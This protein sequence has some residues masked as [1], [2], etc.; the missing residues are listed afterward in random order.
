MIKSRNMPFDNHENFRSSW[1][2]AVGAT[3]HLGPHWTVSARHRLGSDA[4]DQRLPPV[5]PLPDTDRYLLGFGTRVDLTDLGRYSDGAYGHSFA[6]LRPNMDVSANN[7]DPIT[8]AVAL[9]GR[10]DIAVDIVAFSV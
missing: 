10:Y 4:C 8:H 2:L 5:S 1:M 9:K 3:Y 6:F 7:T